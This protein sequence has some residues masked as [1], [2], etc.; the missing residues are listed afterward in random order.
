MRRTQIYAEAADTLSN[1]FMQNAVGSGV[2]E[3]IMLTIDNWIEV[4]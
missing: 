4:R 3:C 1:S 2:Y